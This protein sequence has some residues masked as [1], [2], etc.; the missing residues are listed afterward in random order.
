M[1]AGRIERL[2][3]SRWSYDLDYLM[4]AII[5]YLRGP[6]EYLVDRLFQQRRRRCRRR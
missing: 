2:I 6:I 1:T 3:V 5:L 4:Q